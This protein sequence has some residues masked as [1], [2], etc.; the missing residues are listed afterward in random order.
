M[1]KKEF[2]RLLQN[3]SPVIADILGVTPQNLSYWKKVGVPHYWWGK[4]QSLTAEEVAA[5]RERRNRR[6][7]ENRTIRRKKGD[8]NEN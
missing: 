1:E 8:E 5:V 3:E 7:V 4:I 2:L 6:Q